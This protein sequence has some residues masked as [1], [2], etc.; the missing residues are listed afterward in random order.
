MNRII[1]AS[2]PAIILLLVYKESDSGMRNYIHD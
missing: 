1:W 2:V